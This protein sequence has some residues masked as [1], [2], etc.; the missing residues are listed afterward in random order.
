M[1]IM[2]YL[3]CVGKLVLMDQLERCLSVC[4]RMRTTSYILTSTLTSVLTMERY[5]P[6]F[7]SGKG[8][9]KDQVS[10]FNQSHITVSFSPH[11][12]LLFIFLFFSP[13]FP[14]SFN[15]C[16][17]TRIPQLTMDTDHFLAIF[18]LLL[19]FSLLPYTYLSP[20]FPLLPLV[21]SSPNRG[22]SATECCNRR[23]R[24]TWQHGTFWQ[25]W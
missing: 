6:K 1:W 25:K 5:P 10:L 11:C 21:I 4:V 16:I 23:R 12:L 14:P 22:Y 13:I 17:Y 18:T 7:W 20:A 3:S 9:E 19:F 2:Y 15:F 8:E 24:R